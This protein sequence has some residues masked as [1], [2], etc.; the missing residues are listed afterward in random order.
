MLDD[1]KA[2]IA[3]QRVVVF[4]GTGVSS[5]ASSSPLAGW[6]GFLEAGINVCESMFSSSLPPG[7]AHRQHAALEQGDLDEWLNVAEA[8]SRKLD[9]PRGGEFRRWLRD[10]VGQ[11]QVKRRGLIEALGAL[12]APLV[13]TNYDNLLEDVTARTAITWRADND[14]TRFV[15]DGRLDNVLH[16]HGHWSDSASVVLGVRSYEGIAGHEHA[17]STLRTLLMTH[18]AVFI[19]YGEGLGDSN[20]GALRRWAATALPGVEHRHYRLCLA[21]EAARV[22]RDHEGSGSFRSSTVIP[23]TSWNPLSARSSRT[24]RNPALAAEA[25]GGGGF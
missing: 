14:V 25:G 8:V 24:L 11:L 12:R 10:T 23:T 6:K 20:F 9:A 22:A 17:Q 5:G 16:V 21:S 1:L 13:T 3:A 19:G 15:Q 2:R 18:T 4:V 7:W